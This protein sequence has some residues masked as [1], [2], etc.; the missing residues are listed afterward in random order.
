M[1]SMKMG[2]R[3]VSAVSMPPR[4]GRLVSSPAIFATSCSSIDRHNYWHAM[5]K[6]EAMKRF[7]IVPP[8]KAVRLIP[9]TVE[10]VCDRIKS[11][12][13]ISVLSEEKQKEVLENVRHLFQ[14]KSD[15]E[16]ERK[17]IDKEKGI[18]EYPYTTGE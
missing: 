7:E 4:V 11:K 12:S 2:H 14:S 13:Y 17:W 3:N 15:E 1:K 5:Y 16:L 6:T 9:T 18:F 10:G 8:Q